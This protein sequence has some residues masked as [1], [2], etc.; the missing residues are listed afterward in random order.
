LDA[1]LQAVTGLAGPSRKKMKKVVKKIAAAEI[2][3]VPTTFDDLI[4][5]LIRK[6]FYFCPW[7]EI[8]CS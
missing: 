8:Q 2:R 1:E 6:G 3:R 4:D 7:P 5:E